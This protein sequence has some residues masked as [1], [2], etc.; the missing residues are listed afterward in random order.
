MLISH[1]DR[2]LWPEAG[3]TKLELARY[4][5]A[6]APR[7]LAQAGRSDWCDAQ[8]AREGPMLLSASGVRSGHLGVNVLELGVAIGVACAF[9]CLAVDLPRVAEPFLEK[10]ETVSAALDRPA[11]I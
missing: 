9:V 11:L 8:M 2:V 5:E 7:F 3:I 1:P 6:I 4:Y 10:L